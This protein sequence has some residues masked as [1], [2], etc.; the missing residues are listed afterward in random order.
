MSRWLI[1]VPV[2]GSSYIKTF[3]ELSVPSMRTAASGITNGPAP[4]EIKF[5]IHTD[6]PDAIR[7]ALV[8]WQV[9]FRPVPNKP[10]YVTLQISHA[11]AVAS[12]APGDRV[13]LLNADLVV[14]RNLLTSCAGHFAAGKQAVVLLGIRTPFG[15]ERPPVGAA[16]RD[17]LTWAWNHR[18][19]IIRDL[20]YPHG[21]SM[22]P[23]NLFFSHGDSVVARGF[24]LHPVAIVKGDRTHFRSTIDG[25]LLDCFP[26]EHIHVVTDPDDCALLEVSP[27]ERRF[28]VRSG[29]LS[30]GKVAASMRTRASVT[31]RWLFTHR[32]VVC[33]T[34]EGVNDESVAR[35]IL[36]Y[37]T[38]AK[39]QAPVGV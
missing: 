12:A 28:P 3:V 23:T 30:P 20:E 19:Q 37:L 21:G 27:P 10:T 22:L 24:H 31:H 11:D 35:D 39:G 13:V 36:Q 8:G 17:L 32:I 18:H 5:I 34:G 14:S 9:E 6:Q 4:E 15:H 2:W 1:S 25:D 7:A 38:P 16:P 33:G 29:S 26:R